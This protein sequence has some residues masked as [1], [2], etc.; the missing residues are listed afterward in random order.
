MASQVLP[1]FCR[2]AFTSTRLSMQTGCLY[3]FAIGGNDRPTAVCPGTRQFCPARAFCPLADE[4]KPLKAVRARQ[5]ARWGT[6]SSSAGKAWIMGRFVGCLIA[7]A[8]Y[9]DHTL[10]RSHLPRG[11]QIPSENHPHIMFLQLFRLDTLQSLARCEEE[12]VRLNGLR[13]FLRAEARR[14]RRHARRRS[15]RKFK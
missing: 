14:P 4:G 8:D 7:I 6:K 10:T 2:R 13:D 5:I 3:G 12:P 11:K 15:G 9:C 1:R